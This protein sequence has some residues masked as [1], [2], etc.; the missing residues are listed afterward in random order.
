MNVFFHYI[1][2]DLPILADFPEFYEFQWILV[3]SSEFWTCELT[4]IFLEIF[5][6]KLCDFLVSFHEF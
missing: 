5:L 3:D 2:M 4:W 1:L 6:L